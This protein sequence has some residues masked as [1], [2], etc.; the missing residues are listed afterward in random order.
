ML[1]CTKCKTLAADSMR[2]CPNCKR[3]RGLRPVRE[4]DEVFFMKVSE[5]EAAELEVL[6]EEQAIRH[7][8]EVVKA[9]LAA[10]VY[11][12][13]YMPTDRNLFVAYGDLERAN[14]TVAAEAELTAHPE[15]AA[16]EEDEMPRGKRLVIQT[17]SVLA[18]LLLIVLVVLGTDALAEFLRGLFV[19]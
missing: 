15:P 13:E 14:A 12:P 8:A 18:F 11:D 6:F 10:G 2:T 19:R 16:E 5:T 17:V 3:S 4:E 1:Y 9:G 7:R